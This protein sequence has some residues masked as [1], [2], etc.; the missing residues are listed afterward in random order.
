MIILNLSSFPG[1]REDQE[2]AARRVLFPFLAAEAQHEHAP[3]PYAIVLV[4]KETGTGYELGAFEAPCVTV[5]LA[6]NIRAIVDALREIAD[7]VRDAHA[8][9]LAE[10]EPA[11]DDVDIDPHGLV[12]VMSLAHVRVTAAEVMTWTQDQ[13]Q[14]ALKWASATH[15]SASD[16]DVAVPEQPDFVAV[17]DF[18]V[19]DIVRSRNSGQVVMV[20]GGGVWLES[21][22]E[23]VASRKYDTPGSGATAPAEAEPAAWREQS[24]DAGDVAH[25]PEVE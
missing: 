13:R 12:D 25:M 18:Q 14:Q 10:E 6:A 19:G 23:L 8:D 21:F 3:H 7:E 24:D 5:N 22:Y 11:A 4:E 16:N 1:S 9:V 15:L 2:A 17:G 20:T